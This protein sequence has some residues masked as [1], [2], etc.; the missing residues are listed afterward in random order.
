MQSE[1]E[2]AGQ[3]EKYFDG[4]LSKVVRNT[5]GSSFLHATRMRAADQVDGDL[6][7]PLQ[8]F[9]R[10]AHERLDAYVAGTRGLI[11]SRTTRTFGSFS[12]PLVGCIQATFGSYWPCTSE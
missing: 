3:Q 6:L 9:H 7:L 2:V 5:T 4:S 11:L 10:G 8:R 1:S 12:S